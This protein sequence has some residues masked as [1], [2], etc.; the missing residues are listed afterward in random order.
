MPARKKEF[1]NFTSGENE[2]NKDEEKLKKIKE[3]KIVSKEEKG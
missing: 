1:Y 2:K 3:N